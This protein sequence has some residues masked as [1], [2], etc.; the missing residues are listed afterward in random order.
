MKAESHGR[1]RQQQTAL[2]SVDFIWQEITAIILFVTRFS[3]LLHT[4][5]VRASSWR[6]AWSQESGRGG[7]HVSVCCPFIRLESKCGGNVAN[8]WV[9]WWSSMLRWRPS[10]F[11]ARSQERWRREKK[12]QQHECRNKD[13]HPHHTRQLN[14]SC[15]WCF[16]GVG[17]YNMYT[18]EYIKKKIV[19]YFTAK[20]HTGITSNLWPQ[21]L[22][23]CWQQACGPFLCTA[24]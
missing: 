1:R 4:R 11:W 17:Y 14:N 21:Q 3:S 8:L 19:E 2:K 22:K 24:N 15:N 10:C 23:N 13:S 7:H 20:Y 18:N 16:C 5:A 12:Q 9:S 6:S